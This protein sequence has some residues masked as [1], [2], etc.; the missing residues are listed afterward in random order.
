MTITSD[1]C[2]AARATLM[3]DLVQ[4]TPDLSDMSTLEEVRA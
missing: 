2:A 1:T 4:S 3:A